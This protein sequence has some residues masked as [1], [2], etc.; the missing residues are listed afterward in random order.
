MEFSGNNFDRSGNSGSGLLWIENFH[1]HGKAESLRARTE[2][3]GVAYQHDFARE[4][5]LR[6]L[7]AQVGTDT[8][9]FAWGDD[10]AR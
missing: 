1:P 7:H 5:L 6:E 10:Y 2:Q 3:F 4:G 8:G 9:G